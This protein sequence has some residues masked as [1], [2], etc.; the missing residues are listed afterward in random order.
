MEE[1]RLS[2]VGLG[3]PSMNCAISHLELGHMTAKD[4][5]MNNE[6]K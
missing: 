4:A 5:L 1:T 2:Q 3:S 6:E